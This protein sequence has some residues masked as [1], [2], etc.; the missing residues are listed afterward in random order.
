MS[1]IVSRRDFLKSAASAGAAVSILTACQP[2]AAPTQAPAAQAAPTTAPAANNATA[3]IR[4]LTWYTE[5]QDEY[6]KI[7]ADFQAKNPGV[8]VDLQL[9]TDVT[10]EY[11]PA[12]LAAAAADDLPE[13]YGPHVHSVEFGKKGLAADLVTTLGADFMTDFFPSCVSMFKD[14]NAVYAVGW[15]AQT[16]GIFYDPD[17]FTQAGITAEPQSWDEVIT[18]SNQVK[19][20]IPGNLGFLEIGSDGFS[21]CDVWLPMI[22]GITGDADTLRQLDYH[23]KKWTDQAVVDSLALYGKTLSQGAWQKNLTGM[24]AQDCS[25]AFFQGKAAAFYDGSWDPTTF[26]KQMPADMFKRLK[27]MKTP[28]VTA[29]GRHW[30]GNS[31]GAAFSLANHSKVKDQAIALF[32]FMYSPDIYARTMNNSL[33]MPATKGSMATITDPFMKTMGSW[34]PDGCRH[35]LTGPAGQVIADAIMDFTAGK[36]TDP[37][38]VAQVMEDGAAKLNYS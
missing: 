31:A 32:K 2:A 34:L 10:G 5:Q 3:T 4:W 20:K 9:K 8:K 1:K 21:V 25:T 14:G 16:L 28:S 11:L 35:W 15:M 22:T 33:S 19:S 24:K 12:L 30:T 37:K 13:I 17:Q 18:A 38:A 29:G 6:P 26:S 23:E 36:T 27:V 7:I